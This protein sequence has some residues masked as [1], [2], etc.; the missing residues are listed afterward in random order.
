MNMRNCL[1]AGAATLALAACGPAEQQEGRDMTP[2]EVASELAGVQ[3]E[4]GLWESSAEIIE[5][6]APGMPLEVVAQRKGPRG[7]SRSCITAEQAQR[8][9]ANFL[10]AQQESD[11]TY[12]DF[13]M[14]DG[15]MSGTMTCTGG[16]GEGEM[17][18]QMEGEYGPRSYDMT[19]TMAGEGMGDG[20]QMTMRVRTQARRIGDC[21]GEGD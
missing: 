17:Q 6:E 16:A 9:D 4:P 21:D 3:I 10:A 15:R 7:S 19:M 18:M 1:I 11:C 20:Q 13:S 2:D 14:R 8:P 12:R 5:V